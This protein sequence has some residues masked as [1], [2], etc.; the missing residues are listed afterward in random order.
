MTPCGGPVRPTPARIVPVVTGSTRLRSKRCFALENH[1]AAP[2]AGGAG[3]PEALPGLG[4]RGAASSGLPP[5]SA[6]CCITRLDPGGPLRRK[7]VLLWGQGLGPCSRRRSRLLVSLFVPWCR[8]SAGRDAAS[9]QLASSWGLQETGLGRPVWSLPGPGWQGAGWADCACW[10][11]SVSTGGP[12]VEPA[13]GGSWI[14]WRRVRAAGLIWLPFH[15]V[16]RSRPALRPGSRGP[17]AERC[18]KRSKRP[19]R[20]TCCLRSDLFKVSAW[21][22]GGDCAACLNPGRARRAPCV[23]LSYDPKGWLA[24]AGCN[25]LPPARI[26]TQA[27]VTAKDWASSGSSN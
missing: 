8:R 27:R 21:A 17:R 13:A 15:R 19:D 14:A 5:A 18:C 16:P 2:V 10:R 25:R 3:S 20:S 26:L 11:P 7:P 22:G 23:A 4:A 1:P 12:P 6:A 24:A 9:A